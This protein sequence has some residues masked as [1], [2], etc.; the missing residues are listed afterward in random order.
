LKKRN[1]STKSDIKKAF[2]NLLNSKGFNNL[3]VSDLAREA[4]INRG[5]FYLHYVDKYDLME[6]LEMEVIYDLKQILL[7]DNDTSPID[8][9][10]PLD[11][12]PYNRIVNAL[13]YIKDDFAFIS[14]L[15]GK[16]GDPNFPTLIKDIMHETIQTKIDTVDQLQFRKR[17][18]PEDYAIEILLSGIIAIIMVWIHKG[19]LESPEE[20][21]ALINQTKQLSPYELLL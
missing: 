1:T 5:T 6:K 20:I 11:L 12:I 15:S 21:G 8:M 17:N 9:N 14:A 18:I 4:E 3:T 7:L 13:N 16:G 2:I 19:A 10:Q